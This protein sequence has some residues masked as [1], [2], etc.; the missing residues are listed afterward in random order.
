MTR[1]RMMSIAYDAR[2]RIKQ[3]FNF[4]LPKSVVPQYC[5]LC[6]RI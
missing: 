3:E 1:E 5:F 6:F 4:V 2:A